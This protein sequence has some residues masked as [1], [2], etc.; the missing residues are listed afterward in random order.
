M[1][2]DDLLKDLSEAHPGI[3][4]VLEKDALIVPPE[5]LQ[6]CAMYLKDSPKYQLDFLSSVT[7]VDYLAQGLL[8]SVYHFF[9]IALRTGPFTIKVRVAREDPKIP[10][11]V[12]IYHSAE[13]QEREAYDLF[14]IIY[15]GHPDLRRIFL[16]DEF[17]GHPL[18]KDYI[19]EDQDA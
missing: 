15:T 9:S 7:G 18:R 3:N 4:I 13:F 1:S 19:Q 12:P 5:V 10:T 14:G 16:W 6:S 17:E 2:P 8:E 11:L